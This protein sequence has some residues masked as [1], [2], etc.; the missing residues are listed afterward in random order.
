MPVLFDI[1]PLQT[2]F[3]LCFLFHYIADFHLQGMLGDLKQR[4][5]WQK[6]HPD[7]KYS[8]DYRTAGII[9]AFVWSILTFLPF[10]Q[11]PWYVCAV[12]VNTIIHYIVDDAKANRHLISLS[13]DQSAHLLQIFGTAVL[14]SAHIF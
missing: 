4:E 6:N 14:L 13:T 3:C 9:H 1:L 2:I 10:C 7:P 12:A 11:S 8:G 5:W